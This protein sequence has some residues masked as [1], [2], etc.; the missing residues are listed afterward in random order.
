[1]TTDEK[2]DKILGEL[3]DTKEQQEDMKLQLEEL[4]EKLNE[5]TVPTVGFGYE[6]EYEIDD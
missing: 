4:I 3:A 1:M 5:V 6:R 2:L